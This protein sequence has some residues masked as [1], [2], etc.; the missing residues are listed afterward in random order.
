MRAAQASAASPCDALT[1]AIACPTNSRQPLQ[2]ASENFKLP[3][4][5]EFNFA[6]MLM[7]TIN[8]MDGHILNIYKYL[9]N[10]IKMNLGP[11]VSY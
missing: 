6:T 11:C 5:A 3:D 7:E 2:G 4:G 9:D 1:Q 8:S 10:V